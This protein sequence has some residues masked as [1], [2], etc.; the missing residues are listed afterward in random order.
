[1]R[2]EPP[3]RSRHQQKKSGVGGGRVGQPSADPGQALTQVK[4]MLGAAWVEQ[5]A[6]PPVKLVA[7]ESTL[8]PRANSYAD[9]K[10]ATRHIGDDTLTVLV[11]MQDGTRSTLK[12]IRGVLD[13]AWKRAPASR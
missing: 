10:L 13:P 5:P 12:F 11:E 7:Y 6:N 8:A 4:R 3:K 1:M 9:G 2:P